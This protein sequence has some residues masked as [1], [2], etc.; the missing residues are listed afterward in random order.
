M[1]R[2]NKAVVPKKGTADQ[3]DKVPVVAGR[4]IRVRNTKR[5]KFTNA[6]TQYVAIWVE[7][8]SGKDS[9]EEC[10][11]FTE[12]AI[13]EARYRASKNAEDLTKK[14]FWTDLTD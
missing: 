14:G 12:N 11:L 5:P 10:L 7:G 6:N 2:T 8:P 1:G 13:E 3:I 9:T 4:M